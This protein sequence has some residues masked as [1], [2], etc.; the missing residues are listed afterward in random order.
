MP[1]RWL[2]LLMLVM[3]PVVV[4]LIALVLSVSHNNGGF[5][6]NRLT[7]HCTA[8]ISAQ[9]ESRLTYPG[10]TIVLYASGEGTRTLDEVDDPYSVAYIDVPA[11]QDSVDAWYLSWVEAH[12]WSPYE[13]LSPEDTA[14]RMTASWVRR[15]NAADN[16]PS[17]SLEYAS[18]PA[19]KDGDASHPA[20]PSKQGLTTVQL[21]YKVSLHGGRS[22][23]LCS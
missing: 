16:A 22:S 14:G 20:D 15:K 12:G 5:L 4:V 6:S 8:F 17:A 13:K 2:L 19:N 9:P 18:W 1:K 7:S 11:A 21:T 23:P 3:G 10:G